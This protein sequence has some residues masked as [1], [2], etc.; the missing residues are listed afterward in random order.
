[1]AMG[2]KTKAEVKPGETRNVAFAVWNGS[3][4]QRGGR[5]QY[6]PWAPIEVEAA[7]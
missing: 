6:F 5:K 7:E 3:E 2:D 4:G 1:M